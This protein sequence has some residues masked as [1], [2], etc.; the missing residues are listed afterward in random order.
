MPSFRVHMWEV[1]DEANYS[2]KTFEDMFTA[3]YDK[4]A[5][6]FDDEGFA[7][8]VEEISQISDSS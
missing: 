1:Y 7:S 5:D 4:M 8:D 3:I 2:T 6:M